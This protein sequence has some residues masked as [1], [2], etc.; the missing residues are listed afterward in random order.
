MDTSLHE[1]TEGRGEEMVLIKMIDDATSRTLARFYEADTAEAHFDLLGRWLQKY[2]RPLA[3]YT[4]RRV[5]FAAHKKGQPDY[6][7]GTQFSRTLSQLDIEWI[8]P[9]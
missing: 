6:A 5:S 4:D 3:L 2:G 1:W 9:R 8:T 7:S